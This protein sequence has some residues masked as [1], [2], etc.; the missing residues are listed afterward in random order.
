MKTRTKPFFIA[1][2]GIDGVGKTSLVRK[3]AERLV[4]S[5]YFF[6]ARG[7]GD[8]ERTVEKTV[9]RQ[10]MDWRDWVTGPFA[11][12]LA[13][14]CA[15]DYVI[16][17]NRVVA[18]LF[19]D[20]LGKLHGLT[21][22]E[23]IISDRHAVCFKAYALCNEKPN[24]TALQILDSVPPPDLILYITLPMETIAARRPTD[25]PIDEFEHIEAQKKQLNAYEQV[26]KTI[27]CPVVRVDNSGPFDE[28]CQVLLNKI[29]NI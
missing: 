23:V 26:F 29:E 7:P 16:Y 25:E 6:V 19:S 9:A 18:P 11:D 15:F 14:A 2:C 24:Q 1:V 21:C 5:R 22:P 3:L 4:D 12:A 8:C 27:S 28:T 10:F 20:D 17:Y 13:V